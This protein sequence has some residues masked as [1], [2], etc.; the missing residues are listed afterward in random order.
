MQNKDIHIPAES[1]AQDPKD[2]AKEISFSMQDDNATDQ[3]NDSPP[4]T[5][6]D[7]KDK[8][9]EKD[10]NEAFEM[11][12]G[13]EPINKDPIAVWGIITLLYLSEIMVINAAPGSGKSHVLE[14]LFAAT[15]ANKYGIEIDSI[16]MRIFS[17][18]KALYVDLERTT[19]DCSRG[20]KRIKKRLGLDLP[21]EAINTKGVFEFGDFFCLIG[22]TAPAAKIAFIRKSISSGIYDI[23][24]IDGV[25]ELAPRG[26]NAEEESFAIVR[27]LRALAAQYS[28]SIIVSL[29]PDKSGRGYSGHLG[30]AFYKYCRAFL[31]IV[32]NQLDKRVKTL[33]ANGPHGKLSNGNREEISTSFT[34]CDEQ[35]MFVSTNAPKGTPLFNLKTLE[36][37]FSG[38]VSIPAGEL[39]EKYGKIHDI[40]IKAAETHIAAAKNA[41]ILKMVG[42]GAQIRYELIKDDEERNPF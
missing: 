40:G 24:I 41:L 36:S 31:E 27:E 38:V 17:K 29:H 14:A 5:D 19:D 15:I 23:V 39:K 7:E 10:E 4:N 37:L 18:K 22:A 6:K 30:S 42:G 20:L 28:V 12:L 9:E 8:K 25:L 16:G 11:T 32:P 1:L 13:Y 34:F 3:L 35:K 2:A 33:C 26:Q 21:K